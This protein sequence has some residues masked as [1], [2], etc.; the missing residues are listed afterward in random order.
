MCYPVCS[1]LKW[2]VVMAGRKPLFSIP[3]VRE[4]TLVLIIKLVVIFTI[5]S[6]YFSDPI[7]I[8]SPELSISRQFG[9][10][11]VSPELASSEVSQ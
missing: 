8:S 2:L 11:S 7:N 3:L 5:K 1:Q 9:L 6:L 4:L 10:E